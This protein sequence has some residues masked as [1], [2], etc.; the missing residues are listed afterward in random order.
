VNSL[1]NW[2]KHV[3]TAALSAERHGKIEHRGTAFVAH[4]SDRHQRRV[5]IEINVR[6][7]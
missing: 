4:R 3:E 2:G 6:K 1:D 5:K 7:V